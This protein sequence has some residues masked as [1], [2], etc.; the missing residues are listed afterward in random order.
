MSVILSMGKG[1][2]YNVTS[3][4]AAWSNVPSRGVSVWGVSVQGEVSVQ[5]GLCPEGPPIQ[6]TVGNIHPDVYLLRKYYKTYDFSTDIDHIFLLPK[7]DTI[8]L[9]FPTLIY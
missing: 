9:K 6:R 8:L 7:V 3:C 5:G 2:L 4:L 1:S